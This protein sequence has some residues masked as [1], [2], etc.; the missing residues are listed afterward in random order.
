LTLRFQTTN[1]AVTTILALN[2]ALVNTYLETANMDVVSPVGNQP[3][4]ADDR[5][6]VGRQVRHWRG[7]RSMTLAQVAERSSLNVGYLSQIENDKACPSLDALASLGRALD[8]PTAW[9]LMDATTPPVV[10][11]AASR[12]TW[13]GPGGATR[14]ESVDGGVPRDVRVVR[15]VVEAGGATGFHA[16]AGMEHHVMLAGQL[17]ATQGDHQVQLGPGDYLLWDASIPHNAEAIGEQPVEILI[18]SSRV[19]GTES[20][21]PGE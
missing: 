4:P 5:P 17:R 14:V 21:P 8:V 11:R 9:F 16:H 1:I 13:A 20:T 7:E 12:R 6:R 15:I 3:P 19:S 2:H 18:I 10:V